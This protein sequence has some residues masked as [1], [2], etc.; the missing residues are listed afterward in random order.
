MYVGEEDGFHKLFKYNGPPISYPEQE[1]NDS[2]NSRLK[3]K[4]NKNYNI[5]LKYIQN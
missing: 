3:E 2:R 4:K 5:I 1:I